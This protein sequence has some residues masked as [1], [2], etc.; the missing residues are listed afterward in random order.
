MKN[1]RTHLY[2]VKRMPG[3]DQTNSSETSRHEILEWICFR[4]SHISYLSIPTTG[5][6]RDSLQNVVPAQVG[7]LSYRLNW[8]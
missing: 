4:S 7:A 6:Q 3:G 2:R 5:R 8:N 1:E